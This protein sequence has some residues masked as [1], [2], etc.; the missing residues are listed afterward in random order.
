MYLDANDAGVLVKSQSKIVLQANIIIRTLARVG[1]AALIDE[2]TGYQYD[3]DH[4][5]LQTILN[6][7]ISEEFLKW[8]KRF[9]SNYYKEIFRL[10]N[11]KYDPHSLQKPS[12]IGHFTNKYVYKALPG[13]V[14]SELRRKN[15]KNTNG[16]RLKKHHQLLSEDIGVVHL[17]KHLNKLITVMELSISLDDFNSNFNKIFYNCRQPELDIFNQN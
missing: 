15:P 12:W 17:D 2:A 4:F 5:A 1:I 11:W 3:R 7:Y 14:L 8:Q 9:P 6:A 16:N 10:Y 13:G